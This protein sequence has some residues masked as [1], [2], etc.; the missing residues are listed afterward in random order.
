MKP[1]LVLLACLLFALPASA[2]EIALAVDGWNAETR[3]DGVTYYRCAGKNCAQ[4]SVVSYKRQP[5]RPALT[6]AEYERHHRG[7]AKNNSGQ[8]SI[9]EAQIADVG[10]RA[11]E[12][13][14]VMHVTRV[15]EWTDKSVTYSIEARLIGPDRSYSLVSDSGKPEWTV[16]NY[17]GFLRRLVEIAGIRGN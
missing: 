7:L 17:N 16:N 4:G 1:V 13:V 3:A 12:G 11:V 6:L 15:V 5:H 2:Q 9:R 14:R 10:E 8:G